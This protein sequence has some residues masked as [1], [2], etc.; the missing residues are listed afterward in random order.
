LT[1]DANWIKYIFFIAMPDESSFMSLND[2]KKADSVL[3]KC[4]E[5]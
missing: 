2:F 3:K 5:S 4:L 1:P